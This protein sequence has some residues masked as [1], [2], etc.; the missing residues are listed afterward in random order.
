MMSSENI[1]IA[2]E[3]LPSEYQSV[4]TSEMSKEG[5]SMTPKQIEDVV[6]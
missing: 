2:I 3:K 5:H 6:F 4:L 1:A